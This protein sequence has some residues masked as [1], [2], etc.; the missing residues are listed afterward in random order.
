MIS[1]ILNSYDSNASITVKIHCSVKN[2][3]IIG[4]AKGFSFGEYFSLSK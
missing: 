4:T 1:A 2:S 3:S